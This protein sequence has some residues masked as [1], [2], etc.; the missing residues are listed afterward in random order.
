[1]RLSHQLLGNLVIKDSQFIALKSAGI[2]I[3][4]S[5]L[6]NDAMK[7]QVQIIDSTFTNASFDTESLLT[8]K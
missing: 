1:M 4:S 3:V 7:T 5:N 8:L 6:Q 2:L